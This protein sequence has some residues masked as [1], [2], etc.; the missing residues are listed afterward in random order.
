MVGRSGS[1]RRACRFRSGEASSCS[2]SENRHY[3]PNEIVHQLNAEGPRL[4]SAQYVY[5]FDEAMGQFSGVI[6]EATWILDAIPTILSLR[7]SVVFAVVG[8]SK[9]PY[10]I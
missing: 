3:A 5:S 8:G 4:S 7:G 10:Q 9:A 2:V 1:R 6:R